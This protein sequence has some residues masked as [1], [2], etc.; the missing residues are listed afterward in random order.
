MSRDRRAALKDLFRACNPLVYL[1]TTDYSEAQAD[2]IEAVR[3]VIP[4][5]SDMDVGIW[6]LTQ[7][8]AFGT[9]RTPIGEPDDQLSAPVDALAKIEMMQD[10]VL[11][12]FYNLRQFINDPAVIQQIIDSALVAKERASYIVMIGPELTL[13]P[14]LRTMVTVVPYPLPNQRQIYRLFTTMVRDFSST[15]THNGV[16]WSKIPQTEKKEVVTTAARAAMG[17]D[18]FGAEQAIALSISK[19]SE[20]NA[21][22]IMEHKKSEIAKSDVLEFVADDEPLENVGGFGALKDWLK[23]REMAFSEEAVAYGLKFP[24]GILLTGFPGTGKSLCSKAV[25]Y[26]LKLPVIRMDMGKVFRK[27]IGEA[28][29]A[30]RMA[31]QQVEAA[32]P[33]VLWVDEIEKS[34]AGMSSSGETDSGVSARV[35][36]TLLTWRA[37]TDK[38]VM[39]VATANDVFKLPPELLRKGRLDEIWAT[40]L[41]TDA[42][43]EEIFR[44]H[45]RKRKRDAT[46]FDVALLSKKSKGYVGSEIEAVIEDGMYSAFFEGR[47]VTTKDILNSIKDTQPQSKREG[48]ALDRLRQWMKDKARNVSNSTENEQTEQGSSRIRRI[49]RKED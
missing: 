10:P 49:H 21:R 11:G 42:E 5:K 12:I 38:P 40:D 2:V 41:P 47:E 43:R 48:E 24:K 32:A 29:G 9:I 46:L 30:I 6:K 39:L 31:L 14:E 16:E 27:Y 4:K 8:M 19:T 34:L 28:E 35:G 18:M 23:R 22:L 26:Y 13:P 45:L 1:P 33:A 37:E 3:Q 36:A 17:L 15:L 7:G 25:G 44:I 20:V